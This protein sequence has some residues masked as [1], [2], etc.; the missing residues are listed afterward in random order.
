MQEAKRPSRGLKILKE[1]GLMSAIHY[2]LRK[3]GFTAAYKNEGLLGLLVTIINRKQSWYY[4][5]ENPCWRENLW[6]KPWWTQFLSLPQGYSYI[7]VGSHGVGYAAWLE[8]CKLCGLNPTDLS[9]YHRIDFARYYRKIHEKQN[10]V[11]FGLTLDR[12]YLDSRREKIM[13][14]LQKRV[15][16]FCLV[17]DPISVLKSHANGFFLPVLNTG[18]VSYT[19]LT[20]PTTGN[21]CRSRWSPY[22]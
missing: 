21:T 13:S 9:V 3:K 8:L 7:S 11:F 1:K 18:A 17:R 22:H 10:G 4:R 5:L 12:S 14:R 6:V 2:K 20:L 19:H 16:V 15:P